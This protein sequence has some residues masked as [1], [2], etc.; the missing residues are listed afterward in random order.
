VQS[1]RI[2]FGSGA[3]RDRNASGSDKKK[4]GLEFLPSQLI[5]AS[6]QQ[7]FSDARDDA[8]GVGELGV[9]CSMSVQYSSKSGNTDTHRNSCTDSTLDSRTSCIGR[10]G[11]R[12][13]FPLLPLLPKPVRQL[14]L[15]EPKP[16]RLL[17]MEVKEVFS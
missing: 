13:R 15:P 11:N 8:C 9:W 4:A 14:D 2:S 3:G 10:P 1:C 5:S 16:V 7:L 6:H 12:I 17:P